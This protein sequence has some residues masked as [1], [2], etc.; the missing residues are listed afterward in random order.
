MD[1]LYVFTD[2]LFRIAKRPN[3]YTHISTKTYLDSLVGLRGG[4]IKINLN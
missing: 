1:V 2:E 4:V 3:I